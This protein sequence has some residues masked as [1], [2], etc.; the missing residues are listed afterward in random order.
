MKAE[1]QRIRIIFAVAVSGVLLLQVLWSLLWQARARATIVHLS[2]TEP[3]TLAEFQR[4]FPDT[5]DSHVSGF[6]QFL[7]FGIIAWLL[8]IVWAFVELKYSRSRA[9]NHDTGANSR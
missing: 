9:S 2:S 6:G 8:L 7:W 3:L 1:R 4:A 5:L